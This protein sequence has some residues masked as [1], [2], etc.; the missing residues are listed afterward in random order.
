MRSAELRQ[1]YVASNYTPGF[2]ERSWPIEDVEIDSLI[3]HAN[4]IKDR[5]FRNIVTERI[6]LLSVILDATDPTLYS[7]LAKMIDGVGRELQR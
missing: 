7:D 4:M 1:I 5:Q 2:P 3:S 6:N